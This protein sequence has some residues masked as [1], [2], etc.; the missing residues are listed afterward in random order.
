MYI[1]RL[2][3]STSRL[4]SVRLSW[5]SVVSR[6][7]AQSVACSPAVDTRFLARCRCFA[8]TKR[9][10]IRV[11]F[12][13]N[14]NWTSRQPNCWHWQCNENDIIVCNIQLAAQW[15]KCI[16]KKKRLPIIEWLKSSGGE[17]ELAA[18]NWICGVI[19]Y[20][21]QYLTWTRD[22]R[23]IIKLKIGFTKRGGKHLWRFFLL[24]S[25]IGG[26]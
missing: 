10:R 5:S 4:V 21:V 8:V 23:V 11:W 6:L 18:L 25:K 9:R 3:G 26:T 14:S 2:A 1:N 20:L 16:F 24:L 22:N 19:Y 13:F 12:Q 7:R 17:G 15:L